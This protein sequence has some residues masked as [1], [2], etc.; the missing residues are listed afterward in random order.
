MG[1]HAGAPAAGFA[2]QSRSSFSALACR[3]KLAATLVDPASGRGMHVLTTAP[4]VQFYSGNFLGEGGSFLGKGGG[5]SRC[6]EV[7]RNKRALQV[8]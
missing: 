6:G 2:V 7:R 8:L 3:P 5:L 1:Q 4:G